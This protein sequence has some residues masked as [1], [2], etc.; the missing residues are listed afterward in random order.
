LIESVKSLN[1]RERS[2][3]SPIKLISKITKKSA[4]GSGRYGHY[5]LGGSLSAV[6]NYEF[7]H[8]LYCGTRGLTYCREKRGS[9]RINLNNV[10]AAYERLRQMNP[11]LQQFGLREFRD[12]IIQFHIASTPRRFPVWEF[13]MLAPLADT[14]V[15]EGR[16]KLSEIIVGENMN[17]NSKITFA[18]P[19]LLALAFPWLFTT[20]SGHFSLSKKNNDDNR[21]ERNGGLADATKNGESLK[22]FVKR[23]LLSA[24]RRWAE[25]PLFLFMILDLLERSQIAASN[26]F[27]SNPRGRILQQ[28]HVFNNA[29]QQYLARETSLVPHVVRTSLAYKRRHFLDLFNMFA[30]L[31][32]PQI[33]FTVTCD[34]FAEHVK[35]A[36]FSDQPWKD[37]VLFAMHF[38]RC[39]QEFFFHY[40]IHVFGPKVGNIHEWHYTVEAQMRGSPHRKYQNNLLSIGF[41]LDLFVCVT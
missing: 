5:H 2:Y 21:D 15:N 35:R 8:M 41:F 34:D 6:H 32:P 40:V 24:D 31:G 4:L 7:S 26:F 18:N 33:F 30:E 38:K 37:P 22:Q 25:E 1:Y 10:R 14:P 28:R 36:C 9:T 3:L 39:F 19:S 17:D 13:N 20:A 29:T 16:L 27:V 23:C 12:P 11:L